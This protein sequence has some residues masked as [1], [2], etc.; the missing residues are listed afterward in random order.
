MERRFFKKRKLLQQQSKELGFG[1]TDARQVRLINPDG[2]YNYKRINLSLYK[3]FNVFYFLITAKWLQL[4]LTIFLWYSL[5][6]FVF[7]GMYYAVGVDQLSG[8][9]Y[10]TEIEKFW[11]VYFF[12]AQTLTTV[13]YGRLNPVGF[14]ASSIASFEALVG[15]MSF[16]IITGVLYARFSKAPS[17]VMFSKNAVVAPFTWQG[18]EITGLMFR[19]ANAYNSS[20]ME[21][22]AVVS[23]SLLDFET[24]NTEGQPV[25]RFVS[26]P[27][28]RDM[29]T[30]FPSSWT[31]VHPIDENS[32]FYGLNEADFKKALPEIMILMNGFD[33]TF[34][35]KIYARSSYSAA[36]IVWGAKFVKV[37]GY[38]TE[39]Q[40]TV[41]LSLLDKFEK[42]EIDDL[43]P[44]LEKE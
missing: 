30:F 26:L 32:P 1:T 11:E 13:G 29:L 10:K 25:R 12:S 33:E 16:A 14:S 27:L 19:I 8:M 42:K 28:E 37:F 18:Q 7:V 31:I 23:A 4:M 6:N 36:E 21:M 3:S 35:Q 39:G 34:D 5:V 22:K 43:I 20:L 40:A 2:T 15:L 17:I 44:V 24:L 9:I 41:D 38:D